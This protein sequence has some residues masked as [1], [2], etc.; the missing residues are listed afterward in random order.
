[1]LISS[2]VNPHSWALAGPLFSSVLTLTC[3]LCGF[4]GWTWH[5]RKCWRP[6][7]QNTALTVCSSEADRQAS[8][9]GSPGAGSC[10]LWSPEEAQQRG[11]ANHAWGLWSYWEVPCLSTNKLL[12]SLYLIFLYYKKMIISTPFVDKKL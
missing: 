1:M 11:T 7:I 6:R 3:F 5:I 9:Y 2:A 8:N 4:G 10:A 12:A